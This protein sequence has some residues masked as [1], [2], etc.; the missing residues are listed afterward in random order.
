MDHKTPTNKF[1]FVRKDMLVISLGGI[2][3]LLLMGWIFYNASTPEW[4]DYQAEFQDLVVDKFGESR[5]ATVPHGLQ[6]LFV[7]EL[8]LADRCVTCHLNGMKGM[9]TRAF[10]DAPETNLERHP[11]DK[12]TAILPWRT[13]L[14]H[15]HDVAHISEHWK[16]RFS[17]RNWA[18]SMC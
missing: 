7:K 17:A 3:L 13:G 8:N 2:A 15:R 9:E 11:V 16:N 12:F 10:P 6:Q 1:A 14:C 5:A 4:E 18:I